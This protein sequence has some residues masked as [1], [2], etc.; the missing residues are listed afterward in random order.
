MD[1]PF[2]G[3]YLGLLPDRY[4]RDDHLSKYTEAAY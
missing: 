4:W 1:K 3:N 2:L